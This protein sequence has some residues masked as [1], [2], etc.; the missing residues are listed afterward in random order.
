MP[1]DLPNR[2]T[3]SPSLRNLIVLVMVALG[4][5]MVAYGAYQAREA[6][7]VDRDRTVVGE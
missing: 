4:I 6:S 7:P 5:G 3:S 1:T 2:R